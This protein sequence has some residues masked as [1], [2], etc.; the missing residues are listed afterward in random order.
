MTTARDLMQ[1]VPGCIAANDSLEAAAQQMMDLGVEALPICTDDDLLGFISTRDILGVAVAGR[2]LAEVRAA[3][4]ARESPRLEAVVVEANADVAEVVVRLAHADVDRIPVTEGTTLVGEISREDLA[5]ALP[6]EQYLEFLN[7]LGS[8]HPAPQSP[9]SHRTA[10]AAGETVPTGG[11]RTTQ[12]PQMRS[13]SPINSRLIA[14]ATVI[15]GGVVILG[16]LLATL[17]GLA[18]DGNVVPLAGVIASCAVGLLLM[19]SVDVL[20]CRAAARQRGR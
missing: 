20:S 6:Q 4:F 17:V 2:D 18:V 9:T 16:A 19:R 12:E 5:S 15:V 11:P 13:D 1:S 8:A 14:S 7:E 3:D 10:P